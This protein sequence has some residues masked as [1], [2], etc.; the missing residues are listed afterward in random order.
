MSIHAICSH[1]KNT[2][3]QTKIFGIFN[4]FWTGVSELSFGII[5]SKF[6]MFETPV[7]FRKNFDR[8]KT[9]TFD[10]RESRKSENFWPTQCLT[11]NH[12]FIKDDC[13]K[14]VRY[15]SFTVFNLALMSLFSASFD[16]CFQ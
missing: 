3:F 2:K 12:T 4:Y 9:G 7:Y 14:R 8:R 1:F 13:P 5:F 6:R 15:N 16:S 10:Y 11:L